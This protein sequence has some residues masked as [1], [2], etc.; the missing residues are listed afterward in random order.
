MTSMFATRQTM[1]ANLSQDTFL[2]AVKRLNAVLKSRRKALPALERHSTGEWVDAQDP[3]SSS[4]VQIGANSH[5]PTSHDPVPS[6]IR[7]GWRALLLEP[8][9][10]LFAALKSKYNSSSTSTHERVRLLQAAVCDA[11]CATTTFQMWTVDLALNPWT[12]GSNLSDPRCARVHGVGWVEEIASLSRHTTLRL[13]A[14]LSKGYNKCQAC[15]RLVGRTLPANCMS[16]LVSD[17][18]QP[19]SVRCAC[20][21]TE[22]QS[23]TNGGISLLVIDCEG[24]DFQVLR[25]FPFHLVRVERVIYESTHLSKQDRL[26]AAELMHAL[27]F[28][29]VMA[30]LSSTPGSVWHRD[31]Q[32][33]HI[34]HRSVWNMSMVS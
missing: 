19:I 4:V 33:T 32:Y 30:P 8:V 27:G 13:G 29:S 11:T 26:A 1:Q 2:I 24:H 10:H 17:H 15:S 25:A 22:V 9:P 23:F 5:T 3:A 31:R 28:I 12:V 21:K 18:I 6:A 16:R 34:R 7:Q 14:A 20:L